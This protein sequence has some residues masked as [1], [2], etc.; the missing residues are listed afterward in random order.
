MVWNVFFFFL[1]SNIFIQEN[2]PEISFLV[3]REGDHPFSW[4]EINQLYWENC[5]MA[6]LL[7]SRLSLSYGNFIPEYH[8]CWVIS[9]SF[10]MVTQVDSLS[11]L[12][13]DSITVS[14]HSNLLAVMVCKD[15]L[16]ACRVN[17]RSSHQ[18]HEPTVH[19]TWVR[20]HCNSSHY[21][22]IFI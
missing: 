4:H 6:P 20:I 11:S 12:V 3:N 19:C 18:W 16:V 21:Q 7:W 15:L 22:P 10:F 1:N 9:A 13:L 8:E 14:S 2:V 17:S 5:M